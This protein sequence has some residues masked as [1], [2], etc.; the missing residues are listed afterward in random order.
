[1][2]A[3]LAAPPPGYL[4][5][6]QGRVWVHAEH[7]ERLEALG[8][9]DLAGAFA[10]GPAE[11]RGRYKA[12]A[13]L[14]DPVLTTVF[15]KRYDFHRAEVWLRGA[16]KANPPVFSGPRELHNLLA[17]RAAGLRAPLP[18]AAGEADDGGRRRSFVALGRLAGEPLDAL[19][20]PEASA[21]RRAL[22]EAVADLVGRLHGAGFWHRDLYACNLF[23]HEDEGLG[24]L[25][26][27]RVARREGGPPWR[28]RVKD[29]AALHY[30]LQ[31]PARG[32][33]ERF[34]DRYLEL[35]RP[36][37][38][39]PDALVHAVRRKAARLAR[40]GRKGP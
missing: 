20:P 6:D 5:A 39:K 32:E 33:R 35:Q 38:V 22:V 10:A 16:L 18:L 8:L 24:L 13:R 7:R 23:A 14:P 30:S 9:A 27:E 25:D 15:V 2:S 12:L 21:E 26:C 28:W 3:R 40:R 11:V 19:P 37:L 31:W 36:L 17:L 29:L 1:M 4:A 34:L